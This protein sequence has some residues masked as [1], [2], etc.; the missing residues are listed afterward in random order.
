MWEEVD[1][2][3]CVNWCA[4]ERIYS[5]FKVCLKEEG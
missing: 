2:C 5:N 4:M 1:G 3:L